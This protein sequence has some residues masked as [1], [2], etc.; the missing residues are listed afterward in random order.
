MSKISNSVFIFFQHLAPK[1]LITKAAGFL[2]DKKLGWFT[3][4]VIRRYVKHYGI[5]MELAEKS[6]PLDYE[7]F[8][9]FFTRALKPEIRPVDP[10][11]E[12]VV[13]PVDGTVSQAGKIMSGRIIQAKGFDFSVNTLTGGRRSDSDLLR[14]G[15]FIT[16]YLSPKDYHRVHIP[17]A[18]RLKK[19]IFIP[20][21]LYSVNPLTVSSINEI[22]SRNERLVSVFETDFGDMYVVLVGATIVGSMET[23][24]AGTVKGTEIKE[25][26]YSAQNISFNKGDEIGRFKL[27]STVICCFPKDTVEFGSEIKPYAATRMGT[28]MGKITPKIKQ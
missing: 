27:G 18:G 14:D 23:V 17:F 11:A 24:W 16:I 12:T 4:L 21:R 9:S 6:N 2:A 13:F 26:D 5:D 1:H 3:T 25:W 22:F 15:S 7:T 10:S 20:G 8:N 19:M 28:V